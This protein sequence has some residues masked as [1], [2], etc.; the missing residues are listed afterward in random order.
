MAPALFR[1]VSIARPSWRVRQSFLPSLSG[2]GTYPVRPFAPTQ[3]R[4]MNVAA[5]TILGSE[6]R[7]SSASEMKLVPLIGCNGYSDPELMLTPN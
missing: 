1:R 3:A 5:I 6:Q 4:P 2:Q 7:L